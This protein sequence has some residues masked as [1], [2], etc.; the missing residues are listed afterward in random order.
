MSELE[1]AAKPYSNRLG[2]F[3]VRRWYTQVQEIL[4]NETWQV[5][6]TERPLHKIIVAAVILNPFAGRFETDL[7][8]VVAASDVLGQAF[9]MRLV[10]ALAGSDAESYGK[11]CIVGHAG[12]YEHGNMVLTTTFATPVRQALGDAGTWIP[13]TGKRGGF[14]TSLDI[15][16]ASKQELYSRSHY[17]TVTVTFDDA[18][19][20]DEILVAFAVATAPRVM[21]R[22]GGPAAHAA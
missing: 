12:E 19:A 21:A 11:G 4:A 14:G 5:S 18:P 17:D 10:R 13:S 9:G 7:S 8:P 6:G 1:Y 16:L 2:I 3:Q 15:P 20:P 22:L